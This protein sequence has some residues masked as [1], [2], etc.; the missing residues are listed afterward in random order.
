MARAGETAWPWTSL[1][2]LSMHLDL[3]SITHVVVYNLLYVIPVPE[4]LIP[5]S[6]LHT[7]QVH[8]WETH[9]HAV[10]YSYT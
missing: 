4:D 5:S 3:F 9:K 8:M 10:K 6:E 2:L 1:T 7:N